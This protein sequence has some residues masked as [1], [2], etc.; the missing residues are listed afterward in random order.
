[1]ETKESSMSKIAAR[2]DVSTPRVRVEGTFVAQAEVSHTS[3]CTSCFAE[4][5]ASLWLRLRLQVN[6]S[7]WRGENPKFV[8]LGALSSRS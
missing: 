7:G 8:V 4:W 6:E 1:M 3:G 2:K 5:K